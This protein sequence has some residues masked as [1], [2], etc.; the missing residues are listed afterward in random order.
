M[1]S[2]AQ[3]YS[4][5]EISIQIQG[6]EQLG[7]DVQMIQ[8][9]QSGALGLTANSQGAMA[10]F[11]PQANVFGLPFLFE[12]PEA[13]WEVVDG[14]VGDKVAEIA[15]QRGL[16]VLAW[17]DNG[18]RQIT[19]NRRA[20]E[21]PEDLRGLRI[22]TPE[23]AMTISILERLG[24]SPTPLAFGELYVALRQGAV[25][26]QENPLVNIIAS[27]LDEVQDHLAMV[28]YQYQTT[29]VLVGI[30]TWQ[31]LSENAQEAL[32]KSAEEARD[33]QRE[34]MVAQNDELLEKIQEEGSMQVSFVDTVEFRELTAP[35]YEHW[36]GRLGD[37]VAEAQ[38]AAERANGE[39][40]SGE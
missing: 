14:P 22:R 13:A 19:N 11:V 6:S 3:E 5:G 25:D 24:A 39:L 12:S 9:L 34:L 40:S 17:W 30:M 21:S 36:Q 37:I 2:L 28:D 32:L 29:P 23:D 7:S 20:I 31:R 16:K 1:A 38:E 33:Y 27:N 35:V 18:F 10:N 15:E 4:D 26:G 8:Q